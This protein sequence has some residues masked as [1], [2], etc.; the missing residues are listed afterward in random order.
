MLLLILLAVEFVHSLSLVSAENAVNTE[1]G[2]V[3]DQDWDL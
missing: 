3:G 2:L 1:N